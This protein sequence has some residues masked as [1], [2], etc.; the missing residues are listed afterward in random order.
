MTSSHGDEHTP[1]GAGE[2]EAAIVLLDEHTPTGAGEREAAIVL[3]DEHT[4]TGAGEREAAIV[5]LLMVDPVNPTCTG[6]GK[7]TTSPVD[8]AETTHPQ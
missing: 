1:T 3:L 4:P 8:R 2:R 7:P 5:L 6:K